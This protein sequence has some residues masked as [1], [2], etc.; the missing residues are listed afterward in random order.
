MLARRLV[1]KSLLRDRP[2]NLVVISSLGSPTWDL[3]AS[4]NH[5][6]NFGFVGAMGQA[7]PFALGFALAQPEKRV[8][9]LA[10]DGE[11]LMSLGVLA[12][13]A[14]QKPENLAVVVL[15]NESYGET[16]GQVTATAGATDLELVARGCGL[17]VTRTVTTESEIAELREL[18]FGVGG[19]V[20]AVV[21]V[22]FEE[23][24]PVFPY[25]LDG[26][27]AI[28]RFRSSLHDAGLSA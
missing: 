3:A 21:K 14:N 24:S 15:D 23:L 2:S 17:R 7:G 11:L 13:I 10:G 27:T 19:P 16:G 18:A 25:S 28:D 1:V 20:F 9:L 6:C 22:E 8:V 12:T 4:G 26:V 5:P